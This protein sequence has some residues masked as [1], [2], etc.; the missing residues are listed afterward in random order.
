MAVRSDEFSTIP[1]FGLDTYMASILILGGGFGGLIVAEQLVASLGS[2]HQITLVAPNRRFTFFP[3]LVQLAFGKCRPE[4]IQFD[5]D[6]KL[7]ELGVRYVQGEMIRIHPVR[8][9]VEVAGDDFSGEIAYDY[10][11]IATGRRL[12]TE[13]VPGFFE[14]AQHLLGVKSGVEIWG[15]CGRFSRRKDH[16]RSLS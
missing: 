9:K 16:C 7:R 15:A 11:V 1:L 6:E 5:L 8:R 3:A 12:A 14:N 10:L 2:K 13:K 4:D